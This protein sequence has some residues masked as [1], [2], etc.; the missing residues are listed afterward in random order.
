M[1][2][3][4]VR[5]RFAPLPLASDLT[6]CLFIF[7]RMIGLTY[8]KYIRTSSLVVGPILYE[9]TRRPNSN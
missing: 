5:M 7:F 2:T 6:T 9:L 8:C 3:T 1:T 4:T